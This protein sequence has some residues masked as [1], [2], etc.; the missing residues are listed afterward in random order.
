M[1][2]GDIFGLGGGVS[3]SGALVSRSQ[4]DIPLREGG[5][6]LQVTLVAQI[7]MIER[8]EALYL[9]FK[10]RTAATNREDSYH[11]Y[12]RLQHSESHLQQ[13]GIAS[14]PSILKVCYVKIMT[15]MYV[16]IQAGDTV[17]E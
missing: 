14:S 1:G 7:R 3:H 15:M 12:A 8:Y 9:E 6:R 16:E 11:C 17:P 10:Y 2:L 4:T 13:A 5:R